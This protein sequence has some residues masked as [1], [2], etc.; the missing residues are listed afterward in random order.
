[1]G[2]AQVILGEEDFTFKRVSVPGAGTSAK[3]ITVQ[4]D[5]EEQARRLAP[6][7]KEKVESDVQVASGAEPTPEQAADLASAGI[8]TDTQPS[9]DVSSDYSWFWDAVPTSQSARQG[10]F[11]LA[12]IAVPCKRDWR[13]VQGIPKKCR[14][15]RS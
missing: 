12:H 11:P 10:R 5:P 14:I 8:T 9:S 1:M 13:I 3:R 2:Q 4:I 7:K 15:G 6:K